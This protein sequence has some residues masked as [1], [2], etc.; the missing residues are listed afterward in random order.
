[1]LAMLESVAANRNV[2]TSD[3]LGASYS[4][5]SGDPASL[6]VPG[7]AAVGAEGASLHSDP[8][9]LTPADFGE[10]ASTLPAG[11][12][13]RVVESA[14]VTASDGSS[15][16]HVQGID[17]ASIDGFVQAGDIDPA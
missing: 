12:R 11:T 2:T 4:G 17:D 16:V 8:A 5:T 10:P 13:L 9:S 7:N 1:M 15:V 3:I 14:G 6:A